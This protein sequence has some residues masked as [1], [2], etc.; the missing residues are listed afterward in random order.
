MKRKFEMFML[1]IG[2]FAILAQF[3]LMIQNRLVDI[4]ETI[5]LY[6][7]FFT[8]LTNILVALFFTVTAFQVKK[9]PYKL[10]STSGA[11]TAVT[12]FILIVGLVYQIAL[13]SI[14]EP[15]GLQFIVD[16]LLHTIIPLFMLIYWFFN[17]T[18]DD[19][20]LRTVFKWLVYPVT[21]IIFI[22]VR[23]YLSGYYPYPFLN[24]KEIGFEKTMM[25]ITII[26]A[27]AI[28][29]F[30]VLSSIGNYIVKIQRKK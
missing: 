4:P 11:I 29:I 14:W 21:Y 28:T 23:G 2:W 20:Q 24:I 6:F 26:I 19:L 25:N 17:V 30:V 3:V 5:I 15:T 9:F 1:C 22:I 10:L 16:E 7:S 12:A 8:I 18:K 27:L 13:R